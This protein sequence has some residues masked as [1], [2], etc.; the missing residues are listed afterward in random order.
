MN[1]SLSPFSIAYMCMYL[2]LITWITYQRC[3]HWKNK[4]KQTNKRIDSPFSADTGFPIKHFHVEVP[5]DIYLTYIGL[6]TSAINCFNSKCYDF[7]FSYN[8]KIFFN[9]ILF[10]TYS[11]YILLTAPLQVTPYHNSSSIPSSLPFF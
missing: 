4:T 7:N 8:N 1:F 9:L 11:L 2:G 10:F 3:H 5:C 6:V